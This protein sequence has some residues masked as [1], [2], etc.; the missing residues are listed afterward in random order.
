[1]SLQL[2]ETAGERGHINM[3][4]SIRPMKKEDWTMVSEIYKQGL[5]SNMATFEY[6][7]PPY[8]EWDSNHKTEGRFVAEKNGTIVGWI[9]LSETSQRKV[10]KGVCE[11]SVYIDGSERGRGIGEALI[12]HEI[13]FA[14][15]NNIWT[16]QSTIMD[17]NEHSI[18]LHEK[19][20]FR[21]VGY[22]K[23]IGMDK[24]GNWRNIVLMERRSNVIGFKGCDMSNCKM[25][26]KMF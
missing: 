20:G 19:C 22:R 24:F 11:L 25:K 12:K 4:V 21:R 13:A 17:E 16:L 18:Q 26:D 1:M 6:Q 23:M 2:R 9:A 3:E 14:D 5:E 15:E 10:Y 7:C 8:D